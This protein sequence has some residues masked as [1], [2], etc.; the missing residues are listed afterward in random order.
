MN[1]IVSIANSASRQALAISTTFKG[2][3]QLMD[4]NSGCL[5]IVA[6]HGFSVTGMA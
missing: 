6:H 3:A 4:W 1:D 2:N 5:E